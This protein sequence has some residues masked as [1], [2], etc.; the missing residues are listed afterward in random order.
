VK[1][2]YMQY[3]ELIKRLKDLSREYDDE[4]FD[5]DTLT[6]AARVIERLQRC[7]NLK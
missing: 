3:D 1:G 5:Y 6:T 2:A 7:L 4:S